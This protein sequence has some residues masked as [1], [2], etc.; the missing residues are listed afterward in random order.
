MQPTKKR[1]LPVK[2]SDA[3]GVKRWLETR[4]VGRVH[5]LVIIL[6]LEAAQRAVGATHPPPAPP[7]ERRKKW[8]PQKWSARRLRLGGF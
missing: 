2:I 8:A 5:D 6:P 1:A 7:P 4:H 3:A